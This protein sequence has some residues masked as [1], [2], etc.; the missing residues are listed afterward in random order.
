MADT[1]LDSVGTLILVNW[2]CS[3][4]VRLL[5]EVTVLGPL[6]AVSLVGVKIG[7]RLLLLA[8]ATASSATLP[9]MRS[10][11]FALDA[12]V[13]YWAVVVRQ[14]LCRRVHFERWLMNGLDWILA[15]RNADIQE[16][17]ARV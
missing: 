4:L 1:A 7:N 16:R 5:T 11:V 14:V 8:E 17:E 9:T 12:I 6:G 2:D 10:R 13:A 15:I 3:Q